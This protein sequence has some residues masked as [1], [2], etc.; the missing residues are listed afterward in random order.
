MQNDQEKQKSLDDFWDIERLLPKKKAA[1]TPSPRM[2]V[3][4]VE[5]ELDAPASRENTEASAT[6]AQKLP[7]RSA[8]NA[9]ATPL[10]KKNVPVE[11]I[12][13]YTPHHPLLGEVRIFPWRSSFNF[14]ERFCHIAGALFDRHGAPC[15][16]VPFFSYM[17]QYDQMSRAQLDWY[18][19]WR[20][21]VRKGEYPDTDYSYIFLYLFEIINLSERI[22][23]PEGQ[24]M[25]CDIWRQYR[26]AY[27]LLNRY[28]ADWIC[29]YSLIHQLPPPTD[30]LVGLLPVMA[31][32][33]SFKEF[34]ACPSDNDGT[35]EA[36]IYLTFCTN[37][38]YRKSKLYLSG[39]EQAAAMDEQIP[40]AISA[41]IRA[42][43]H[44][45]T[46]F[47]HSKMQKA[48]LGRDSFIGA[49]CS[50]N[51]KRRIEVDYC[52]FNRSHELRFLV[53]DIIKYT[54]NRLRTVFGMK[55]RLSIYGL[56]EQ[57]K[58][59]LDDYLEK[60]FPSKRRLIAQERP[61]YEALY[62]VP[63]TVVSL[64][65]AKEI[66]QTS[67]DMTRQLVEA[68]EE[69]IAPAAAAVAVTA[70]PEVPTPTAG[71]SELTGALTPYRD[72][73]RAIDQGDVKQQQSI[74]RSMGKMMDAVVEEINTLASDV[75]GDILIEDEGNGYALIEDYRS[76]VASLL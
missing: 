59:A 62:D 55:S 73:L 50:G 1:V 63:A 27:P 2:S 33:S 46:A 75:M 41:V 71:E 36:G 37:Y 65:H 31:E 58:V 26:K 7:T 72:L 24:R 57:V 23:P 5:I 32:N 9:G 39:K 43:E 22:S 16:A 10:A 54:E 74:C 70:E 64:E 40:G 28:L 3:E 30:A 15:D 47:S 21:C 25:M 11:P 14:Y 45:N 38:D 35:Q 51:M 56:P 42:L 18:L 20:D 66:E 4:A 6:I 29:D 8:I 17:P 52:S 49:L 34:Y 12:L 68:F 69:D 48:T 61:A 13:T 53:T 67:W 44:Q 76:E 60:A 19:Y